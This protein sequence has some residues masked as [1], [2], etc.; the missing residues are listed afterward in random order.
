MTHPRMYSDDDP[1]L[2]ELRRVCLAFPE[3]AEVEAWGRPTF[4]AGKKMFALFGGDDEHPYAVIV[5]AD[6]AERRALLDDGRFYVPPYHGPS[7]WVA[8]D[9]TAADVDWDEVRELVDA[10]YRQV[11]LKRMLTALDSAG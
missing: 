4:R 2:A 5:K 3:A 10:S 11:A 8:L 9:F 1:Y 6:P 7:G